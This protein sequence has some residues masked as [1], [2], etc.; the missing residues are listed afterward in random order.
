MNMCIKNGFLV[1]RYKLGALVGLVSAFLMQSAGAVSPPQNEIPYV[2]GDTIYWT[3]PYWHQVQSRATSVFVCRG[4][5]SCQVTNGSYWVTEHRP[6]GSGSGWLLEVVDGENGE[7]P[8]L[9]AETFADAVT[10]N[11]A[12]ISWPEG[13]WYQ[14]QDTETYTEHC[15]GYISSCKLASPGGYKVTNHSLGLNTVVYLGQD[16]EPVIPENPILKGPVLSLPDNGWYQVQTADTYQT[17][18]EGVRS[19]TLLPGIYNVINHTSGER[20]EGLVVPVEL[21]V[22]PSELTQAQCAAQGGSV[23]GDIGDG[24]IHQPEYRCASGAAPIGPISYSEVDLVPNE[25]AV[26]CL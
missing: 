22:A 20:W 15:Y 26:C 3:S 18:C 13:G 14:V 11:G 21:I 12:V 2:V 25:G 23:I 5:T 10:V 9:T 8:E 6:D 16:I 19:C 7:T 24:A 4:G 17:V 1:R